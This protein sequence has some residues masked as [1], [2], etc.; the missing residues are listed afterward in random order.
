MIKALE[1]YFVLQLLRIRR[2]NINWYI[3]L[4]VPTKETGPDTEE[5]FYLKD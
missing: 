5:V 2:K 1:R 4:Y 3:Y